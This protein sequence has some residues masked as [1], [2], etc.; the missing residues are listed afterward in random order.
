M[1]EMINALL[2]LQTANFIRFGILVEHLDRKGIVTRAEIDL[3]YENLP[4]E[5]KEAAYAK[6]KALFFATFEE[7]F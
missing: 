4:D 2:N 6:T 3:A 7:F 1:K 5:E